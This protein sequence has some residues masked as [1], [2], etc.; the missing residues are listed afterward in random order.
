MEPPRGSWRELRFVDGTGVENEELAKLGGT[1]GSLL[2]KQERSTQ[3]VFEDLR[4]GVIGIEQIESGITSTTLASGPPAPLM[5]VTVEHRW[6][7]ILI[8]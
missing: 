1:S 7:E 8:E 5:E 4:T 3:E 6:D 2:L